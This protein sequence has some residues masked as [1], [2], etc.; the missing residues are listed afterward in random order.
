[1]STSATIPIILITF[2]Y[3]RIVKHEGPRF[4][5]NRPAW[6]LKSFIRLYNLFQV[7]ACT[8]LVVGFYR[9]GF[10]LTSTFQSC[11]NFTMETYKP[12]ADLC[13][14]IFMLK[15]LDL[16][17]TVTF[18]M[19]KKYNQISTLHVFHHMGTFAF[20]WVFL[21]FAFQKFFLFIIVLNTMV[22]VVMYAYY[23]IST[24]PVCNT[25]S[26]AVKPYL[27]AMQIVQLIMIFV[28][29]SLAYCQGCEQPLGIRIVFL[30]FGGALV[31]LFMQLFVKS[32]MK[33]S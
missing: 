25:F 5:E 17:E 3:Y 15:V 18:V 20:S 2:L 30:I 32:Y 31:I 12:Y 9:L 6:Q 23:C 26:K 27:T 14:W 29:A 16:T 4:M 19:R 21:K 22:H 13:W 10:T 7:A 11:E 8:W 1:M 28:R 33:K 24:F